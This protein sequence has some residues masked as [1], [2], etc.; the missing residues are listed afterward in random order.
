LVRVKRVRIGPSAEI[1]GS[2]KVVG[3]R[4]AEISAGAKLGSPVEFSRAK[5]GPDYASKRYYWHRVL[6]W[7]ASFFFGFVLLLIAPAFFYQVQSACKRVMPALGMGAVF[8]IVAPIAAILAAITIVGLGVGIAVVLL[9]VIA[10]YSAQVFV[11]SWIGE[12]ILGAGIGLG[13]ALGRL[14]LG[15]VIV[16]ACEM[17]PIAGH[18]W[19]LAV[20]IWGLGALVITIYR[21][22]RPEQVAAA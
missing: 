9:Y 16:R 19:T 20:W 6:G 1:K 15:L 12:K 10:L 3:E 5:H 7:G 8:L 22:I 4:P 21:H 17:V 2:T 18:L 11:S 13:P 14:A